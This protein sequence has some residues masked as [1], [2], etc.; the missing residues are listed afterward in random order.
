[1]VFVSYAKTTDRTLRVVVMVVMV[2]VPA[3]E[4]A[5]RPAAEAARSEA[6]VAEARTMTLENTAGQAAVKCC[7]AKDHA[8]LSAAN[9]GEK[10]CIGDEAGRSR[11]QPACS[12][13][14]GGARCA[15]AH[16]NTPA[17]RQ[18]G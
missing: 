7:S 9:A 3:V 16:H 8:P 11:V 17:T 10:G 13:I 6:K 4:L 14:A 15:C 12:A 5:R 2:V 18:R 1:M